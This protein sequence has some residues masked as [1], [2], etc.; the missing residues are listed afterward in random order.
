MVIFNITCIILI[1]LIILIR[2]STRSVGLH[3]LAPP[4]CAIYTDKNTRTVFFLISEYTGYVFSRKRY[5]FATQRQTIFKH[6]SVMFGFGTGLFCVLAIPFFQ[7]MCIPLG[8][9]G[10]VRLLHEEGEL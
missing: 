9:V 4:S 8:V 5:D 2:D 6:K 7:F 3:N 1:I 10:A